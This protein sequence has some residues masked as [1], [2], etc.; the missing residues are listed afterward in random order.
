MADLPAKNTRQSLFLYFLDFFIFIFAECQVL[1][2]DPFT[3][4]KFFVCSLPSVALG[5]GFA[6]CIWAFA[7]CQRHSA[8]PLCPVVYI[9]YNFSST[10]GLIGSI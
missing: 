8:K 1:D 7:E 4:Q 5:K 6:K 9:W 10:H 2:K 3:D